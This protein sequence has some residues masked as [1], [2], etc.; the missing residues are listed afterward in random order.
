MPTEASMKSVLCSLLLVSSVVLAADTLTGKWSGSFGITTPDGGTH[1]DS[2]YLNIKEDKGVVEGTAG[3]GPDKQW[4]IQKGKLDGNKLTFE[5][6]AEHG[7]IKFDLVFDGE[8]IKG[9]AGGELPD[10][11]KLTAKLDL[12]RAE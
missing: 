9:T 6:Q 12:K 4:N 5:V 7:L 1:P 8:F 3:P 10:G 11:T 2:A